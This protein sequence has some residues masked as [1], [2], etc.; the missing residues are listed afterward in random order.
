MRSV[1]PTASL[2]LIDAI[3]VQDK[4]WYWEPDDGAARWTAYEPSLC[5]KLERNFQLWLLAKSSTCPICAGRRAT[6]P[7]D[8]AAIDG[9]V[10]HEFRPGVMWRFR[11]L[12]AS[13]H[14]LH[15]Q[16]SAALVLALLCRL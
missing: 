1:D 16:V 5:Q 12:C 6:L 13:G 14:S 7:L 10:I 11:F 4:T 2:R 3:Q 8:F 9:T 15:V